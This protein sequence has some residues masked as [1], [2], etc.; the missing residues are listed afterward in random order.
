MVGAFF[1]DSGTHADSSVVALGGLLGTDQQWEV[2]AQKWRAL[3]DRP[4]ERKEK[5]PDFHLTHCRQRFGAFETWSLPERDR[6]T[7][8]FREIIFGVGLVT[9]AAAVN[10]KA[11]DTLVVGEV[12]EKLGSSPI[13]LCF[14][15][16]IDFVVEMVRGNKPDEKVFILLDQGTKRALQ[17]WATAY[18]NQ[19]ERYP[20]IEGIG[21]GPVK[22]EVGLQGADMIAYE[23][24]QYAIEWFQDRDNAK[25]NSHFQPFR[26]HAL[27]MGLVF[28]TDQIAEMV[29]RVKNGPPPG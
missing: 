25:G 9:I 20:E 13:E 15:K 6:I 7:Y 17:Q 24:Y 27:S 22:K 14:V 11:W 21:F 26:H 12:A 18:R 10:K 3:L 2:F 19:P 29:K 8:L 28:D 16:C 23:T 1:D 5:L 4:L